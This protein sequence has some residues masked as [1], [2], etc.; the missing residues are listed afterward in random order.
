MTTNYVRILTPTLQ[1]TQLFA[2]RLIYIEEVET[3]TST[4]RFPL[5]TS[6]CMEWFTKH[7]PLCF[8]SLKWSSQLSVL[9]ILLSNG[10]IIITQLNTPQC[11]LES[12]IIINSSSRCK[13]TLTGGLYQHHCT[14]KLQTVNISDALLTCQCIDFSGTQ[15]NKNQLLLLGGGNTINIIAVRPLMAPHLHISSIQTTC[16]GCFPTSINSIDMISDITTSLAAPAAV[17]TSH[18]QQHHGRLAVAGKHSDVHLISYAMDYNG[19]SVTHTHFAV[20]WSKRP[21][22]SPIES[23]SCGRDSSMLLVC[24]M[25]VLKS[26]SL[27]DS[28]DGLTVQVHADRVSA[29]SCTNTSHPLTDL[30]ITSS[31]DGN[32]ATTKINSNTH[33]HTQS[34][35]TATNRVC[36]TTTYT[37][38][39]LAL[40]PLHLMLVTASIFAFDDDSTIIKSL[41]NRQVLRFLSS[42][43]FHYLHI[44]NP[45]TLGDIIYNMIDLSSISSQKQYSFIGFHLFLL[46]CIDNLQFSTAGKVFD[47]LIRNNARI[48]MKYRT[49]DA[50]AHKDK[51]VPLPV[52]LA[53]VTEVVMAAVDSALSRSLSA[54]VV[55]FAT[56]LISDQ[57]F[58]IPAGSLIR[59][60]KDGGG[61]EEGTGSI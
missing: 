60:G 44:L 57:M 31:L 45:E 58:S 15:L 24:S 22:D 29:I 26:L 4:L 25:G 16:I 56:L 7:D 41:K 19:E 27:H 10:E 21:F 40:D 8:H 47:I 11:D 53:A 6:Q 9:A 12:D 35:Q 23:I 18:G 59:G 13:V 17:T 28:S 32:I 30:L 54:P 37:P 39:G 48:G 49:H 46:H 61:W 55:N 43:S 42:P 50:D 36:G 51:V 3:A 2:S 52:L 20:L 1:S 33:T 34:V 5:N 14:L 38:V